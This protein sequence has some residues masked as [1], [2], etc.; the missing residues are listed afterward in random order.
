MPRRALVGAAGF[1]STPAFLG[2]QKVNLS[3]LSH[4]S[5]DAPLSTVIALLSCINIP[6]ETVVRPLCRN[7]NDAS[8]DHYFPLHSILAQR[9]STFKDQAIIRSL[10]IDWIPGRQA[11]VM[12]SSLE[13][14]FI[15]GSWGPLPW[16]PLV[17]GFHW[18][19]SA[20]PGERVV[21]DFLCSLPLANVQTLRFADPP[22]SSAF[23]K[24]TLGHLRDLRHIYMTSGKMPDPSSVLFVTDATAHKD[25]E[26]QDL[27]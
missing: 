6:L 18:R 26:N 22:Y 17:V 14:Y 27:F 8:P 11:R 23:W 12:F 2:F 1:L 3:H 25:V 7:E 16:I 21:N 10:I 24:K 15:E 5:V 20:L 9:F 13:G 19:E 4:L